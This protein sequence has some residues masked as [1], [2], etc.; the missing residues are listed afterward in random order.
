MQNNLKALTPAEFEYINNKY[1]F[2]LSD[3]DI[4]V[5]TKGFNRKTIHSIDEGF[6]INTP[7]RKVKFSKRAIDLWKDIFKDKY[8]L[9]EVQNALSILLIMKQD[10]SVESIEKQLKR[11]DA[12]IKI[13]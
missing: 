2:E 6:S 10:D 4:V 13:I 7:I 8:T 9:V 1:T 3:S 12:Q 11:K 5:S